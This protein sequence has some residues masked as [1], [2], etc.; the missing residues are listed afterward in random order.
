MGDENGSWTPAPSSALAIMHIPLDWKF[1]MKQNYLLNYT[2]VLVV[3][4]PYRVSDSKV[5]YEGF[6]EVLFMRLVLLSMRKIDVDS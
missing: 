5:P 2:Y 3:V 1:M 6:T 4:Q